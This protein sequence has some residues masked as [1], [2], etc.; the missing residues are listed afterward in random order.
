MPTK[1]SL[2]RYDE[3]QPTGSS[4]SLDADPYRMSRMLSSNRLMDSMSTLSVSG[5]D[6]TTTTRTDGRGRQA[7]RSVSVARIGLALLITGYVLWLYLAGRGFYFYVV[8]EW[9][10]FASRAD[11]S[12]GAYLRPFNGHLIALPVLI[13]QIMLRLFGLGS[14]APWLGL[15]A[16]AHVTCVVLLFEYARRRA[17]PLVGLGCA[18]ILLFFSQGAEDLFWAF[19]I[20]FF[21]SLALGLVAILL[22]QDRP[23]TWRRSFA[24]SACLMAATAMS[25]VGLVMTVVF[26]ALM[27]RPKE[28][29]VLAPP[30]AMW[31]LWWVSWSS[32]SP[33][34]PGGSVVAYG[35]AA[36]RVIG[37]ILV[38]PTGPGAAVVP[39]IAL[40]AL[41]GYLC[42]WRPT[43]WTIAGLAG[44]GVL[45][46]SIG[47]RGGWLPVMAEPSRYRYV[48]MALLLVAAAPLAGQLLAPVA[49][50]GH[51]H[52]AASVGV[53]A[54]L[55]VVLAVPLALG[56]VGF[57]HA[58]ANWEFWSL[59]FRAQARVVDARGVQLAPGI[60]FERN[61]ITIAMY[62]SVMDRWG[63]PRYNSYTL[64]LLSQPPFVAAAQR[65]S[66]QVNAMSP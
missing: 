59:N 9:V 63:P 33:Q 40:V 12:L 62:R 43:R 48:G 46:A 11:P 36:S 57:P 2:R 54:V 44:L 60:K 24:M 14:Y 53:T 65:M 37:E 38:S 21:G 26:L 32:G 22:A 8:D 4:W 35:L 49:A 28:L 19:Q 7:V 1:S 58:I 52:R 56:L 50:G 66:S 6:E 61:Q 13:Y 18:A 27:R 64:A 25:G 20:G 34:A 10:L 55:A 51:R 42:G 45:Y 15:A 29:L 23:W 31:A 5:V 30:V 16:A 47:F 39:M 17:G 41:I 3:Y